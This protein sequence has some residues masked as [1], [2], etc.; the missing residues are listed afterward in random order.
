VG[1]YVDDLTIAAA[2]LDSL[3]EFKRE[4]SKRYDMKDL[5][6][7]HFILGLQVTRDRA[8]RSLSLCQTQY[9]DS[10]LA[11]FN[12]QDCKPA[13]YPLRAKT[14]LKPRAADEEKA[15]LAL[16]LAVVGSLMYAM[17][18]TRPDIAYAVGLLG[19]F[20]SDPSIEHWMAACGVL[21]YLKHT[22]MLGI[23][24]SDGQT[25][26]DGFSDAD[27]ATSDPS[28]RRVTS[29]YCFR[30]WGGPI[31]WQS[32]RQPS[33]SLATGDAEYVALA[34]AARE[35]MWLRSLLTELGFAPSRSIKLYGDNQASISIAHNPVG[36]TRAK[37]IDIRFHYLRELVERSVLSIEYVKTTAM[38][39]D[40]L[41]KPLPPVTFT[42]FVDML[43]L[44][45]RS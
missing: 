10:V 23:E 17:L 24:F 39:A 8:K 25:E 6:E 40:G 44:R 31:S 37:Q 38:L 1:V 14:I 28:R 35:A 2:R 12:M 15:D 43:G 7:L 5:G 19:R 9:I 41:T 11:R 21:M 30:L 4:M 22:R 20:S 27:F 16:Y 26:L 18:G 45:S 34:Q 29:G 32:K 42:R 13:K 36:H 33:V 3:E